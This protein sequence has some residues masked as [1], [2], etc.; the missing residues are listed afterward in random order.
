M[1]AACL[2]LATLLAGLPI[3]ASAEDI[4]EWTTSRSGG[5]VIEIPV[6]M[7]EGWVRG[8][9]EGDEDFGTA[10]EPVDYPV[11]LRQ[12]RTKS[13]E[14]PYSYLKRALGEDGSKITY[15]FDQPHLGAI[16]GYSPDGE[17]VFYGMCRLETVVVCFDMNWKK[18][19]QDMFAPIVE[20]VAQSFRRSR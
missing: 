9:L 14:R 11:Q 7:T 5:S 16:S 19:A 1:R 10:F 6:F 15:T 2:A 3:L 4:I 17:F 12:Y 20:R 13:S 8:F 18:E